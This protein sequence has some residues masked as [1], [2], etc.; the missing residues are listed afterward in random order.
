MDGFIDYD[1]FNECLD[2]LC[3]QCDMYW[4]DG[5]CVKNCKWA[6]YHAW[7]QPDFVEKEN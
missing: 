7:L 3:N 2:E 4:V 1:I 5:Y 6:K